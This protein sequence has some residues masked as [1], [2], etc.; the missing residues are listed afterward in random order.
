MLRLYSGISLL[1]GV[2]AGSADILLR[3]HS[4]NAYGVNC[5]SHSVICSGGT[6]YYWANALSITVTSFLFLLFVG[7]PIIIAGRIGKRRNRRG[8]LAWR[9]LQLGW[10]RLHHGSQAANGS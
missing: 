7:Y 5:G 9:L 6:A 3:T 8:Y 4:D 10:T 2:A 1:V